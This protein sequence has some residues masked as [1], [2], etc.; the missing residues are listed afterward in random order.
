MVSPQ[1]IYL[2][3]SA[4]ALALGAVGGIPQILR[5]LKPK[6]S[7]KIME[8]EIQR[9]EKENHYKL[10]LK[11]INEIKWWRRRS[12]AKGVKSEMFIMDK[13]YEQQNGI[14]NINLSNH[15]L[16]GAK[17][18]KET[19]FHK[20]L[21]PK[22]PYTFIVVVSCDQGVRTQEKITYQF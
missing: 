19:V 17:V 13:N 18:Y 5:W 22:E 6:P 4:L 14:L 12:D 20:N 1:D 7:L 9:T 2:L 8:V 16:A 10:H 3:V 21:K 15:L 11:V